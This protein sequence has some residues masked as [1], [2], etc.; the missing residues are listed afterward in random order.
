MLNNLSVQPVSETYKKFLCL[1]ISLLIEFRKHADRQGFWLING[2]CTQKWNHR[3][4]IEE[5]IGNVEGLEKE[6]KRAAFGEVGAFG[7][8]SRKLGGRR[9]GIF[10]TFLFICS[11]DLRLAL[12]ILKK[13]QELSPFAVQLCTKTVNQSYS[14]DAFVLIPIFLLVTAKDI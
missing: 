2:V 3:G 14:C 12:V 10:S 13:H 4:K 1:P 7:K 9:E 6:M 11:L 5:K 8:Y